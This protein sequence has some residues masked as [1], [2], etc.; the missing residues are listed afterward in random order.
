MCKWLREYSQNHKAYHYYLKGM[1]IPYPKDYVLFIEDVVYSGLFEY[2]NTILA[3]YVNGKSCLDLL[4]D[5]VSESRYSASRQQCVG[6]HALLHGVTDEWDLQGNL[7]G[8]R[9]Q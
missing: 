2:E 3:C 5:I 4:C 1:D 7:K 8:T 9:D 6:Q